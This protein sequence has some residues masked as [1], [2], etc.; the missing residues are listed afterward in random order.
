MVMRTVPI[1][2]YTSRHGLPRRPRSSC[3][4]SSAGW[5]RCCCSRSARACSACWIVLRGLAFYSHAVGTAAFPGAR[6]GRRPRLRRSAR[7]AR[8]GR[9]CSRWWSP[10]LGAPRA[11]GP[12]EPTALALAGD[13]GARGD[14]RKRR[15]P[16]RARTSSRCCSAACCWSSRATSCSP[17]VAS[18][19]ALAATLTPRARLARARLRPGGGARA[20]GARRA[21]DDALLLALVALVVDRRAVGA[22]R[23]ARGRA[24]RRA[25]RDRAP[26]DATACCPGRWRPSRSRRPRAR[27]PVAVGRAERAARARRSRCSPAAVFALVGAPRGRRLHARCAS[28]VAAAR[29]PR[30]AL[31]RSPAAADAA[32]AAPRSRVVATTTQVGDWARTVG[33]DAVDVHQILRPNTR[34]ARVRAAARRRRRRSPAPTS[35]SRAAATST[36]GCDERGRA[37]PGSDAEVVDLGRSDWRHERRRGA[38]SRPALVA[39]PAQR[40]SAPSQ[41]SRDALVRGRARAR[42]GRSRATRAAT[43][44]ALRALDRAHRALHRARSRRAAQARHRPRRVRVLRR[45]ATASTSSAR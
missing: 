45:T 5:S 11:H 22:R 15:L 4:S 38:A 17:R 6:A 8:G 13:A 41:R 34:P 12:D 27:R 35:S 3:P 37:M 7:R 36:P 10:A 44:A 28:A 33:G 42:A 32:T 25:G 29:S 18:A 14:P 23:A 20:R 24:G 31:A 19:A 9:R 16:V 2:W 39:R 21:L 43:C 1:I 40:A 30:S 26:L